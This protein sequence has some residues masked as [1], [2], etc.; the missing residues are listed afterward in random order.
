METL[1]HIDLSIPVIWQYTNEVR[2]AVDRVMQAHAGLLRQATQMVASELVENALKYGQ[3]TPELQ[4]IRFTLWLTEQEVIIEVTNGVCDR[5]AL[6]EFEARIATIKQSDNKEE[7]LL[8][9]M[10]EIIARPTFESQL[11]LYRI[12]SE[13]GFQL[14]YN[15]NVSALTVRATRRID[16]Q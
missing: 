10:Q 16:G 15:Y 8:T 4:Q 1:G 12:V 5:T 2:Q 3:A 14:E 7:L 9:R 11:G 6:A 13:G